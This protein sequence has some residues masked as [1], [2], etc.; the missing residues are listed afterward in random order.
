MAHEGADLPWWRV[1]RAGGSFPLRHEVAALERY[2]AEGTPL[3]QGGATR[4]VDM[5]RARWSPE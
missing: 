4:R 2:R 5:G 1:V 3:K